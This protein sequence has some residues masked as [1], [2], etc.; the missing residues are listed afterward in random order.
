[1]AKKKTLNPFKRKLPYVFAFFAIF[2]WVILSI[3]GEP[4]KDISLSLNV[5]LFLIF[6]GSMFL[7]GWVTILV[8]EG[9][10]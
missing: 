9:L 10:N 4:S 5:L 1:L 7:F 6:V 2:S 8:N 3:F